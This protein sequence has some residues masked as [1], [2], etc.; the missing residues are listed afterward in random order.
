VTN[1]GRGNR[2]VALSVKWMPP[3]N[4]EVDLYSTTTTTGVLYFSAW[5]RTTHLR[6]E[7]DFENLKPSETDAVIQLNLG[8]H[9]FHAHSQFFRSH[10]A[11]DP[12]W[13]DC[14][15]NGAAVG[16]AIA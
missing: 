3:S 5:K 14:S 9:I 1:N 15:P 7:R 16:D 8:Q 10:P 13:A 4:P 2:H 6:R 12:A 11:C